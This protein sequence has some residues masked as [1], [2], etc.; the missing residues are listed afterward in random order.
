M[1]N[2]ISALRASGAV[3]DF[4]LAN[5]EILIHFANSHNIDYVFIRIQMLLHL[6][7]YEEIRIKDNPVDV[8]EEIEAKIVNLWCVYKHTYDS[9]YAKT[10]LQTISSGSIFK[11]K[12]VLVISDTPILI[13]VYFKEV[14][15]DVA[16]KINNDLHYIRSDRGD[17]FISYGLYIGNAEI[18]Y[19]CASFSLCKRGY[20]LDSLNIFCGLSL[21][22]SDVLSMTR[23]FGF[24]GS[25]HNSMSKLFH[26]SHEQIKKDFT[27]VKAII[28]AMNP[29][30]GFNGGIFSGASYSPYMLSPMEYWYNDEGNY[31]PRSKGVYLQKST[32]PPIIWL[33]HGLNKDIASSIESIDINKIQTISR[34][35]YN[36]G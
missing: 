23:A 21:P 32:T 11:G 36:Q 6:P 17:N 18:P 24:N 12:K 16:S 9:L 22:P 20:Q 19:A 10:N 35:Q 31:V 13:P 26:L 8:L 7:Y 30:L 5:E 4:V 28:T 15:L 34:D 2:I 3:G 25:P 14:P 29:F 27:G 33:A 1:K